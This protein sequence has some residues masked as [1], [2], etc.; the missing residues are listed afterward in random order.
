MS[1]AGAAPTTQTPATTPP[2]VDILEALK[3]SIVAGPQVACTG[4]IKRQKQSR[5]VPVSLAVYSPSVLGLALMRWCI[6]TV[7]DPDG[8]RHS[9]VQATRTFDACAPVARIKLT[10]Q[11]TH[12]PSPM[13]TIWEKRR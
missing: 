6:V 12:T 5:K 2:V 1:E 9:V 13:I 4:E 3:K 8:R 11:R 10:T 7:T